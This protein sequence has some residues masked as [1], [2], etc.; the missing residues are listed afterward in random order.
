MKCCVFVCDLFLCVF[1]CASATSTGFLQGLENT[2]GGVC[3][4]KSMK[5]VLRVGQSEC[6]VFVCRPVERRAACGAA[7]TV[8]LHSDY[9]HSSVIISPLLW[10][11]VVTRCNPNHILTLN[12]PKSLILPRWQ[13][14]DICFILHAIFQPGFCCQYSFL[15]CLY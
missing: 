1:V 15:L 3:R 2:K 6:F 7:Q 9:S 10:N 5:L 8:R 11:E 12:D 13:L 14:K 4:T